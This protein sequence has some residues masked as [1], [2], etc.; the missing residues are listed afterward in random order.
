M[1]QLAFVASEENN[2]FVQL[3]DFT[4]EKARV[5]KVFHTTITTTLGG[6]LGNSP[7]F[8]HFC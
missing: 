6:F 7:S 2:L 3:W 8:S 5:S 1:A 4:D